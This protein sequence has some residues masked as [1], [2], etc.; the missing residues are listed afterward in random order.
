MLMDNSALRPKYRLQATR[1][2]L[3]AGN[4][5]T[6]PP[7]PG[8]GPQF[9]GPHPLEHRCAFWLYAG[10]CPPTVERRAIPQYTVPPGAAG[11]LAARERAINFRP[12]RQLEAG[13]PGDRDSAVSPCRVRG[14]AQPRRTRVAP[15]HRL[16]MLRLWLV[17]PLMYHSRC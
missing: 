8:P 5:A 12:G 1:H 9:K 14:A 3:S 6:V 17:P 11:L 16:Y 13:R 10:G 2:V 7:V 15:R 4:G